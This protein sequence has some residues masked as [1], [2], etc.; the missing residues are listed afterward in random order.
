MAM[1]NIFFFNLRECAIYNLKIRYINF[2]TYEDR[3]ELHESHNNHV[4]VMFPPFTIN[5]PSTYHYY[6]H[7]IKSSFMTH[8]TQRRVQHLAHLDARVNPL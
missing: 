7:E 6:G 2:V 1:Q 8:A 4:T 5:H 3:M